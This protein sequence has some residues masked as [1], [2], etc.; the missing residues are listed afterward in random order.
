MVHYYQL[1]M[2]ELI[3][4]IHHVCQINQVKFILICIWTIV[5]FIVKGNGTLFKYDGVAL[6]PKSSLTILAGSLKSNQTYQFQ[7]SIENRQNSSI[8]SIGYVLIKVEDT[9][10]QMIVIG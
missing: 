7:V 2:K 1:M 8:K 5:L 10:S 4:S 6:S 3:H 9:Y